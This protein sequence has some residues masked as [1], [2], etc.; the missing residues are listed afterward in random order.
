MFTSEDV[1][2]RNPDVMVFPVIP[3]VTRFWGSFDD[4]QKRRGW[5]GITAVR[6]GSLYELPRDFISRP[7][8]RLVDALEMLETMVHASS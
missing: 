7:G 5:D 2:K 6:N 8:P 4:V 3:G 1:I